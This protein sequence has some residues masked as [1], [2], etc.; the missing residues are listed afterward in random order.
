M[1]RKETLKLLRLKSTMTTIYPTYQMQ[2]PIA[3]LGL[4]THATI[5]MAW[6]MMLWTV[7]LS[8]A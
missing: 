6:K 8:M 4:M 7:S 5:K 1:F 2:I 3:R